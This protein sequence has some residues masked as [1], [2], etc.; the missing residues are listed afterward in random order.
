M[1]PGQPC[2][3]IVG[4][5]EPRRLHSL[6]NPTGEIF[7]PLAQ[8]EDVLPQVLL[9]RT[10]THARE[11]I[12]AIAAGLRRVPE[13][14][15]FVTVR[16]LEGLADAGARSWRLGTTL[17]GLFGAVAIVLAAVGLYVSLAF[18]VRQRVVEIGLRIALGATPG[19][20]ARTVLG[21]GAWLIGL[22]CALGLG[23]SLLFARLIESL[24]FGVAPTDPWLFGVA[25]VVV[26]TAGAAGCLLPVVR[27]ARVDPVV[28]LRNE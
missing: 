28:A 26:C 24:L 21:H 4:I 25:S 12:A 6:V 23:G 11:E 3:D 10:T 16:T 2:I 7:Y 22:G 18:S 5:S 1:A 20:V 15:S 13:V 8:R 9:L 14:G 17:F 27:A 19:R